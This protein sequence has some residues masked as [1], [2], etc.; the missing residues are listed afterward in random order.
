MVDPSLWPT[1]GRGT[2][3]AVEEPRPLKASE[4]AVGKLVGLWNGRQAQPAEVIE[5]RGNVGMGGRRIFRVRVASSGTD[6]LEFDA[7]L[8][9]LVEP[10]PTKSSTR[11][12]TAS[13][14]RAVKTG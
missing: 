1:L 8:E 10:A 2:V 11:R 6:G 7:P 3:R 14:R 13:K 9:A 5:D 12:S 4:V